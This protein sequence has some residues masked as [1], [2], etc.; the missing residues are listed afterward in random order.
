MADETWT[1]EVDREACIGSGVCASVAPLH[2]SVEDGR[3]Q[4]RAERVAPVEEL[5]DVVVLCP[6]AAVIVRD[7]VGE[8]VE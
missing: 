7:G 3:S 8:P 1:V 6:G 4:P 2:F 5:R